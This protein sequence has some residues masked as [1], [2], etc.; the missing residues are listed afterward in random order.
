MHCWINGD[1]EALLVS[2]TVCEAGQEVRNRIEVV[3][4]LRANIDA[5]L[6]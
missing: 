1:I 5:L 3:E 6:I 4:R 2:I